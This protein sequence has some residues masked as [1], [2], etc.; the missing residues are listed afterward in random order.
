MVG[1]HLL[2]EE[3]THILAEEVVILREDS[4][5]ASVHQGLGTAGLWPIGA[6]ISGLGVLQPREGG[7]E[8]GNS[9]SARRKKETLH[10]LHM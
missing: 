3:A 8:D 1:H 10:I 4:A 9:L 5:S 2:L 7:I 6:D